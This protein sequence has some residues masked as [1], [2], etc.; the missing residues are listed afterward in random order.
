MRVSTVLAVAFSAALQAAPPVLMLSADGLGANQFSARTMPG[1]WALSEQGRRG[2]GLPP[3]PATTFN[4]HVSLATGC[5]PEHHGV[6]ANGYLDPATKALVPTASRTEDVQREPLWVAATRSGVRTAVFQW[7]GATGPWE[8][9]SPWRLETFRAGRPDSEALAFSEAALKDGAGLVMTYLSGTDEE[10]HLQGPHSAEAEAKLKRMDEE[11]A[12]WLRRMQVEHPGLRV[13]VAAD[14]GMAPMRRRIHLPTLLDGIGSELITHGGSA[15]IYLQNPK[16]APR[17]LARLRR[18][19]LQAWTRDRVP[20][21][22]HLSGNPRVGDLVVLAKE[23]QWLSKARSSREEQ[24]ERHGRHGAHAYTSET[25]AM[26]TWLIVLG[27]GRGSL[28]PVPL[29]DLAPTVASWLDIRWARRPD[30]KAVPSLV[31]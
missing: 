22:Y 2:E 7:V 20:T 14:H 15:Y 3:F 16:D 31:K 26:H 9:V 11:L 25:P 24:D 21:R 27:A 8:G 17:A 28:G 23:G 10:G 29:W 18:A 4:G 6:V 13:I 1:L 19:G 30:G 12:P 5:W